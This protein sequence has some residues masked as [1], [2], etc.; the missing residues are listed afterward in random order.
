LGYAPRSIQHIADSADEGLGNCDLDAIEVVSLNQPTTQMHFQP[1]AH[2][3]RRFPCQI[4]A[5]GACCTCMGN[6]IF[7]LERLHEQRLLS[8]QQTFLIGQQAESPVDGT[9]TSI[10][11]GQCAA[12]KGQADVCID[13][14][15]PSA[16]I[17]YRRVR[18][19]FC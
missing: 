5:E 12:Q 3:S 15:P 18:S 10:A 13:V 19:Y 16:G 11:V 9:G 14:C 4:M 1:P 7:A 17:I 6:L 8:K 2:Y